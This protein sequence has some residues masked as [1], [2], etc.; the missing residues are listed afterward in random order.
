MVLPARSGLYRRDTDRQGVLHPG[1]HLL[2]IQPQLLVVD[3]GSM[4]RMGRAAV[5]VDLDDPRGGLGLGLEITNC[6]LDLQAGQHLRDSPNVISAA[7]AGSFSA[8]P[9][10]DCGLP[11]GRLGV[12][13]QSNSC[14]A[15][16]S[17]SAPKGTPDPQREQPSAYRCVSSK[18]PRRSSFLIEPPEIHRTGVTVT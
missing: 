13:A 14:P 6:G 9:C 10:R 15:R 4:R 3:G 2:G 1:F 18:S 7:A 11:V 8:P 16:P 17:T 12:D 5:V